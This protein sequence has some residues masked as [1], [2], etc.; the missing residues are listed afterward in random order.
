MDP[1]NQQYYDLGA[2]APAPAPWFRRRDVLVRLGIGVGSVVVVVLVVLYIYRV[3]TFN[4]AD[5]AKETATQALLSEAEARCADADD[6]EACMDEARTDTAEA[7][8]SSLACKGLEGQELKNCAQLIA[9][10]EADIEACA[11]IDDDADRTD[12]EDAATLMKAETDGDYA[13]CASI[14]SSDLKTSCEDQL[15]GVVI[16]AGECETY[17]ISAAKCSFQAD[18]DAVVM[19]GNPTACTSFVGDD[20]VACE[21]AFASAD[22]D[23]DG[24]SRLEEYQLGTSDDTADTDGDGYTD[25]Q[26]VASG[27]DP[28]R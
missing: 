22:A 19:A 21:S 18:L 27:H 20:R 6:P 1:N 10:D 24:L 2:P 3:V 8:G 12:C 28:L 25:G 4:A 26:E 15:T 23:G 5:E 9:I 17:G 13:L 16:A 11:V 7:T 14:I